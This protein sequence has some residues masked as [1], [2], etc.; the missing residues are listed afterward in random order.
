M[1]PSRIFGKDRLEPDSCRQRLCWHA[2]VAVAEAVV[3]AGK[4]C[5]RQRHC[6]HAGV[7]VVEAVVEAFL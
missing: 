3:E 7:A 5:N 1:A 2:G 6:W 4:S